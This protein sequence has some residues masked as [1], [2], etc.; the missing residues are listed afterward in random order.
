MYL[1]SVHNEILLEHSLGPCPTQ[2]GD[3][4]LFA[5]VCTILMLTCRH[6]T[7]PGVSRCCAGQK[8]VKACGLRSL[9]AAEAPCRLSFN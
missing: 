8:D 2:F 4:G 9:A 7:G 5:I 3:M 1:Y 6:D